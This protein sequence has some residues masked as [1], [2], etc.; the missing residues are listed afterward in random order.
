MSTLLSSL[1][2]ASSRPHDAMAIHEQC[3][4]DLI[5]NDDLDEPLPKD[6]AKIATA[7]AELLKRAYQRNGEWRGGKEVGEYVELN[8]ELEGKFGKDGSFRAVGQ[9][10][11]WKREGAD[12]LGVYKSPGV[13]DFLGQDASE[14]HENI[15]WRLER[16]GEGV[17]KRGAGGGGEVDEGV[18]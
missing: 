18:D 13:W 5:I 10:D 16:G 7:H 15:L 4:R 17:R 12:E 3:L 8:K 14:K 6:A 1:Y 11:K 2:T 9:F